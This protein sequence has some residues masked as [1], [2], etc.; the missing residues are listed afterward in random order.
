MNPDFSLRLSQA[1]S[2]TISTPIDAASALL[3]RATPHVA[4]F[5]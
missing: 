4:G 2:E 3:N 1:E 5:M